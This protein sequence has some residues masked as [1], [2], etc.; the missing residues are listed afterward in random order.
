[1]G[2]SRR[3]SGCSAGSMSSARSAISRRKRPC[4]Q[5]CGALFSCATRTRRCPSRQTLEGF[6]YFDLESNHLSYL[7]LRGVHLLYDKD[8]KEAG[9][10]EGRFVLTRQLNPGVRDLSDDAVRGLTLEPN[11][12]NTRLLYENPELG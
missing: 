3:R 5:P 8:G 4:V 7:P 2:R 10:V 9:R 11:A 6:L 1:M 12:E